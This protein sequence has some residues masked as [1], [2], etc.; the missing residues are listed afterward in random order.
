MSLSYTC[1][2]LIKLPL[3]KATVTLAC[4]SFSHGHVV[5]KVVANIEALD[6]TEIAEYH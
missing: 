6:F 3:G 1:V 2:T 5:N 4:F